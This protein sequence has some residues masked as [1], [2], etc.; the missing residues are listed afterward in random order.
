M[1]FVWRGFVEH[2]PNGSHLWS[3]SENPHNSS[4]L[5]DF[6]I[7]FEDLFKLIFSASCM[8]TGDGG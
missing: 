3:V 2:Q 6:G 7:K 5:W 1:Y 4:T 8:Q